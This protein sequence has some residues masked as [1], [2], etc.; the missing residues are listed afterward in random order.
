MFF[1]TP[2]QFPRMR[3]G[4]VPCLHLGRPEKA[5]PKIRSFSVKRSLEREQ[6]ESLATPPTVVHIANNDKFEVCEN[7]D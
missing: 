6:H 2:Y 5:V 1:Y 4:A 3:K 7:H